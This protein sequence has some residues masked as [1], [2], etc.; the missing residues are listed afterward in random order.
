MGLFDK[1][2]LLGG[3]RLTDTFKQDEPFILFDLACISEA[4]PMKDGDNADKS[5]LIVGNVDKDGN[6]KGD[7]Y[8]VGTL[9]TPIAALAKTNL[10]G[11]DGKPVDTDDLPSIVC[12]TKVPTPNYPSDAVVLS[13][14]APADKVAMPKDL[15]PF[16]LPPITEDQNPL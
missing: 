14:L 9:S 13:F 1:D 8:K 11:A 6:L 10:R 12:W 15:P 4:V 7:I 3:N 16:V 5:E 2:R